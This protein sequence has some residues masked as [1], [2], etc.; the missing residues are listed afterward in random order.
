VKSADNLKRHFVAGVQ[1]LDTCF[2][3]VIVSVDCEPRRDIDDGAR[4]MEGTRLDSADS[5]PES[6]LL[7]SSADVLVIECRG[8]I[9]NPRL[10]SRKEARVQDLY[11]CDKVTFKLSALFTHPTL[12]ALNAAVGFFFDLICRLFAPNAGYS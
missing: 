8:L 10:R 4:A 1:V 5:T 11:S 3:S 12:A 2:T 6:R 9:R 7:P